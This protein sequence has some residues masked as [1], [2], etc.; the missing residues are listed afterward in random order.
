M[1]LG[2]EIRGDA[3]LIAR[4]RLAGFSVDGVS[5]CVVGR[6]P[7]GP[8]TVNVPVL[9]GG[10]LPTNDQLDLVRAALDDA[11]L[12]G[13]DVRAVAPQIVTA[14]VAATLVGTADTADVEAAILAWWRA[15]I[16]I[17][18]GVSEAALHAGATAGLAGVTSINYSSPAADLPAQP[19]IWYSPAIT[20][21]R[22]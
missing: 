16:G 2:Y 12:G 7:R 14:V 22:G 1:L 20:V 13:D 8:G 19:G 4:Y 11:G 6:A 3:H 5:S 21:T 10:R 15:H 9:F 18:D 17:G